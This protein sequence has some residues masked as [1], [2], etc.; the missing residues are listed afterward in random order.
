MA[1]MVKSACSVGD[2][3]SIPGLGRSPGE[4]NGSPLQ[5]CNLE[6]PMDRVV[7]WATVHGVTKSWTWLSDFT[8]LLMYSLSIIVFLDHLCYFLFFINWEGCTLSYWRKRFYPVSSTG[9]GLAVLR[10][11]FRP[12]C[13]LFTCVCFC[14]SPH[15]YMLCW[16]SCPWAKGRS[17]STGGSRMSL[18]SPCCFQELWRVTFYLGRN[19]TKNDMKK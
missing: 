15:C 9:V 10:G 18:S 19:M 4:G 13:C 8:I 5:Y 14:F 3:V 16:G 2:P 6:N 11:M 12:E 17:A 1:H 7:W